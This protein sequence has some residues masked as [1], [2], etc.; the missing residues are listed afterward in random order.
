MAN[1]QNLRPFTSDQS[2]EKAV[3]NGRKGGIASGKKKRE[4]KTFKEL[5]NT[6]LNGDFKEEEFKQKMI[7]F[8]IPEGECTNKM[9]VV[10]S[11]WN[12][13]VKGNT[14]AME[15]LRDTAGEQLTQKIE[16]INPPT[17]KIERPADNE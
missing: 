2:R 1:E 11:A 16:T 9:A 12:Q 6:F 4:N 5:I 8:G 13:A 17:I 14:K 3:K 15:I 10:F 7:E